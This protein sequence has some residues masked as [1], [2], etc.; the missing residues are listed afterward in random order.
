MRTTYDTD[1]LVLKAQL[2][3]EEYKRAIANSDMEHKINLLGQEKAELNRDIQIKV[4]V[5]VCVLVCVSVYVCMCVRVC[6]CVCSC[7]CVCVCIII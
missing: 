4:W 3:N 5:G 6:V 7:A 1:L 2:E